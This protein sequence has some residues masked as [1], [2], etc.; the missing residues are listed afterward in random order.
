MESSQSCLAS[1]AKPYLSTSLVNQSLVNTAVSEPM[2]SSPS[3][4]H[5]AVCQL[6]LSTSHSLSATVDIL[7]CLNLSLPTLL[8]SLTLQRLRLSLSLYQ[9]FPSSVP[10]NPVSVPVALY[11]DLPLYSALT[12]LTLSLPGHDDHSCNR[13]GCTYAKKVASLSPKAM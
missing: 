4:R 1:P 3:T 11:L 13:Y 9:L 6:G 12:P 5:E 8:L 2:L 7:T 10:L